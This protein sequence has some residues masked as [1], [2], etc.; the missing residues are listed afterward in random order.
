MMAHTQSQSL[1]TKKEE[2]VPALAGTVGSGSGPDFPEHGLAINEPVLPELTGV[3]S[4]SSD[5]N[6]FYILIAGL[7]LSG[8]GW[9]G[10]RGRISKSKGK[11]KLVF[12]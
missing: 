12:N 8:L 9:W 11:R 10:F 1:E 5:Y 7:G 2:N 6:W 4:S 3:E